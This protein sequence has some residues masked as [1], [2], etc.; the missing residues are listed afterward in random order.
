MLNS[1]CNTQYYIKYVCYNDKQNGSNHCYDCFF[2]FSRKF[3]RFSM[4]NMDN[5]AYVKKVVFDLA[6][7]ALMVGT[8]TINTL[9][10]K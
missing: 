4:Q 8:G 2:V 9:A 5:M 7:A 1:S 6:I 3:H 10:A